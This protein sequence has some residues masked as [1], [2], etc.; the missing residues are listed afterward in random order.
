MLLRE[1][2]EAM[3]RILVDSDQPAQ[4]LVDF[5]TTVLITT[6]DPAG[7]WGKL[8]DHVSLAIARYLNRSTA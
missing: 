7:N 4:L 1:E 5:V 6:P 3:A 2:I 8:Q